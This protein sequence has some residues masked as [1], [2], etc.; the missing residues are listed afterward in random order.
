M[1]ANNP[2]ITILTDNSREREIIEFYWSFKDDFK[3]EYSAK[4]IADIFQL[5]VN[6][7]ASL[8]RAKSHFL[9]SCSECGAEIKSGNF[10]RTDAQTPISN[11]L[12]EGKFLCPIHQKSY[13]VNSYVQK[14]PTPETKLANLKIAAQNDVWK[15]LDNFS[16]HVLFIISQGNSNKEIY[17]GLRDINYEDNGNIPWKTITSLE[18]KD[19]IW[20]KRDSEGKVV[21]FI[22][23]EKLKDDFNKLVEEDNKSRLSNEVQNSIKITLLKSNNYSQWNKH[24]RGT[25][26]MS[27]TVELLKNTLV[28]YEAVMNDD[29]TFSLHLFTRE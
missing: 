3:H 7:V 16:C 4:E 25:F 29:G 17:D 20:V 11:H 24:Y 26:N 12:I 10:I 14:Q 8:V 2:L 28:Q 1:E 27:H 19:L 15:E 22:L 23:D 13:F 21:K 9:L 6:Q 18:R 5:T